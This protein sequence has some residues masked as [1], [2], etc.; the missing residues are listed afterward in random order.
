M[1]LVAVL[2]E[3]CFRGQLVHGQAE[4]EDV[5]LGQVAVVFI[6]NLLWEVSRVSILDLGVLHHGHEPKVPDFEHVL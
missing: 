3:L 6:E 5:D 1:P 4:R 2:W